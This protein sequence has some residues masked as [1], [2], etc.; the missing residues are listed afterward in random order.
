[1]D[2]SSLLRYS[3][4]ILLPEMG[5]EGQ[6]RLINSHV[7]I[8]GLGGLGSPVA[9]YL[10]AAGVGKLTL[11]DDDEVDLSNL[12]RQIVHSTETIGQTKVGSAQ[13]QLARLNPGCTVDIHARRL[14]EEDLPEMIQQV[15]LVLDCSDNFSTRFLLNRVCHAQ[16]TPLVSAAAIRW[17]GQISVF[18]YQ[19]DTA[20]YQCLYSDNGA[21]DAL[22]CSE[23]GVIAPLVGV[24]GSLQALEAIKLLSHTGTIL[25]S[26]LM[27]FDGLQHTWR[28]IK[29][30][31]DPA[32]PICGTHT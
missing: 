31:P 28:S 23:N 5:I 6:E 29:L 7:L 24:I 30:N 27:L 10:A 22:N 17:E 25:Q 12:Q 14:T 4:Q 19:Q 26:R 8:I 20:C 1:M 2:D 16:Q 15:D 21:E 18:T 9:M 32:C 11:V 3:R 13:H